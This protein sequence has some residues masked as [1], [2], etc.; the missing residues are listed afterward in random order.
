MR[1]KSFQVIFMYDR[2]VAALDK[3]DLVVVDSFYYHD[4]PAVLRGRDPG[5]FLAKPE[6]VRLLQWK[7]SRGKWRWSAALKPSTA[8]FLRFIRRPSPMW[9]LTATLLHSGGQAEANGFRQGLGRSSGR[10]GIV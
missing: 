1:D 10:V 9:F 7:L 5:P 4:L 8:F 6:L 2:R 3:P